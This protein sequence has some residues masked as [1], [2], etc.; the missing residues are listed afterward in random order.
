MEQETQ[1]VPFAASAVQDETSVSTSTAASVASDCPSEARDMTTMSTGTALDQIEGSAEQAG[2]MVAKMAAKTAAKSGQHAGQKAVLQATA[3][4]ETAGESQ[5]DATVMVRKVLKAMI[6]VSMIEELLSDTIV[7]VDGLH[8]TKEGT[9]PMLSLLQSA[10]RDAKANMK[11]WNEQTTAAIKTGKL[12]KLCTLPDGSSC[13]EGVAFSAEMNKAVEGF[14]AAIQPSM[15]NLAG[16][17]KKTN[18]NSRKIEEALRKAKDAFLKASEAFL[19]TV[20]TWDNKDTEIKSEA[21]V[22]FQV[23]QLEANIKAIK[24]RSC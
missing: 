4:T 19:S 11:T 5:T 22:D 17:A 14:L 1:T 8:R 12:R 24:S 7:V 16:V 9:R 10:I 20:K 18:T 2:R 3:G 21:G 6:A 13:S 15:I 23:A